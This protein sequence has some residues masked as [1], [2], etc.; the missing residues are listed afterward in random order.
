MPL[1]REGTLLLEA[2]RALPRDPTRA[3]ELVR[4]HARE[5]PTSQLAPER[6]R[7]AA[8]ARSLGDA[9]TRE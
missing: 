4:Q 5:F 3:L 1:P 2:R 6:E 8:E 7:I 9:A